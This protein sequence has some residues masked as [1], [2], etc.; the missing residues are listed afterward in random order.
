[1]S[2][3]SRAKRKREEDNPGDGEVEEM[4]KKQKL[5]QELWSEAQTR[6]LLTSEI[7]GVLDDIKDLHCKIYTLREKIETDR[8]KAAYAVKDEELKGFSHTYNIQPTHM[9]LLPVLM[10]WNFKASV[11]S[12]SQNY[13]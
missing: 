2:E 12:H 9:Y 4:A 3:A 7:R 8:I 11:R 5:Y 6:G 1:M 10:L 13:N